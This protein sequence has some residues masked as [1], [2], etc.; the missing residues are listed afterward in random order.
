MNVWIPALRYAP[1]GMTGSPFKYSDPLISGKYETNLLV[2]A[3]L[4]ANLLILKRRFRE[5]ARSC[6]R[7]LDFSR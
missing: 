2:G 1:A 5:Q 4:P 6:G 3:G 7:N